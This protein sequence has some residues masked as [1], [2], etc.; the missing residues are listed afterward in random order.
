MHKSLCSLS[1]LQQTFLHRD[2]LLN[3][4]YS[5]IVHY[6]NITITNIGNI[7]FFLKKYKILCIKYFKHFVLYL[8]PG[9]YLQKFSSLVS[10]MQLME[11]ESHLS[12]S[13]SEGDKLVRK[14]YCLMSENGCCNLKCTKQRTKLDTTKADTVLHIR[15]YE[16]IFYSNAGVMI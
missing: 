10:K 4:R 5:I 11:D 7:I 13:Y 16:F 15:V 9:K 1:Y 3:L 14:S 2:S 12:V 8:I 6:L